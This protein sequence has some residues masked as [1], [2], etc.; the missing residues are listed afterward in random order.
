MSLLRR[1]GDWI[2]ERTGYR[3]LLHAALDEKVPGGARARY[4]FGSVLL[5]VLVNQLVT[6]LLLAAG[7]APSVHDAWSSVAYI[8]YVAPLGWFIRGMHS[9][10]ASM[11]LC[12]L[13]MHLM[14]VT[15]A[16]AYRRPR[17]MTWW[18]GLAL[19][20]LLLAFGLTGYLLPWDQK[21]YFATQVATS[22]MGV[23]PVV[24]H[25]L[26]R[27]VQGG[28]HYG[29]LTLT[30]FYSLHVLLLP[31]LML[32]TLTAHVALF[33]RHGVT[34]PAALDEAT[35]Q[36]KAG[37]FYPTQVAIDLVAASVC[38]AA[39]VWW[40]VRTHGTSLEAPADPSSGYEAR[41]EWYFLPLF[42][43]LRL[44]PSSL[45]LAGAFG[46]PLVVGGILF[47]LPLID[48]S[49]DRRASARKL[50]IALVV[51]I[52]LGAAV[53]S[54]SA[55]LDDA[56]DPAVAAGRALAEQ[57]A[58][59]AALRFRARVGGEPLSA[60]EKKTFGVGVYAQHCAGCHTLH[61]QGEARAPDLERWA[62]RSWIDAFLAA[63]DAPR[64][65][66]HTEI[67][68]MKPVMVEGAD[69]AA[70]IEWLWAQGG[71]DRSDAA[72][73]KAGEALFDG[74]GCTDC[75]EKDGTTGG[76]GVPNLGG[77]AS[78]YWVK[79]LLADPGADHL[80]GKKN[81]MP[82]FGSKLS[83]VE[84]DALVELLRAERLR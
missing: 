28:D 24:G 61:G 19:L 3:A 62:S 38:A 13:V 66:G 82:R 76:S 57:Q 81:Q 64:F 29:N 77:R 79:Q 12:V 26:Q 34:P 50:P 27:V 78:A 6:G 47:G 60:V 71:A 15:W 16:G 74:L 84:V 49:P 83:P 36:K 9:A 46:A 10:G 40:V 63:P 32:A 73:V 68:G 44:L 69:R 37:R 75:H 72:K 70:L 2:E 55:R 23:T 5:F 45:E 17:E 67:H 7:Y 33:R 30:R 4:V 48:R 31:L 8:Q 43:L 21:G 52:L 42:Q 22:L 18:M 58:D 41:P 65:F 80:Y 25:E 59:L 11:A 54:L 14:Q 20:G 35:L 53:L 51:G 39:L 56:Q 1:A